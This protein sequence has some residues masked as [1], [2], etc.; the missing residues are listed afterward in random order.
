MRSYAWFTTS[1]VAPSCDT[2]I[3]ARR[4]NIVS[5]VLADIMAT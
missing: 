5:V 3:L 2:G 1:F 4:Y